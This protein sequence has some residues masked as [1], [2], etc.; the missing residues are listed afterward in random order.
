MIKSQYNTDFL[1]GRDKKFLVDDFVMDRGKTICVK[2]N[3][4][5]VKSVPISAISYLPKQIHLIAKNNQPTTIDKNEIYNAIVATISRSR[6]YLAVLQLYL[7]V[8]FWRIVAIFIDVFN[9]KNSFTNPSLSKLYLVFLLLEIALISISAS[10]PIIPKHS[11]YP[12]TLRKEILRNAMLL[13]SPRNG[14]CH[15]FA[16]KPMRKYLNLL[17]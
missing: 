7:S 13:A 12:S 5:S 16:F 2:V 15:W 4:R 3:P 1:S 17:Y 9:G 14:A 8:F 6:N 11:A 10:P